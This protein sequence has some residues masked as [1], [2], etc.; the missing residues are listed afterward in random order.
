MKIEEQRAIVA[1]KIMG[2]E[3]TKT[4]FPVGSGLYKTTPIYAKGDGKYEVVADYAP[5]LELPWN[6]EQARDL[7]AKLRELVM[8]YDISWI[9]SRQFYRSRICGEHKVY[10]SESKL[11]GGAALLENASKLAIAEATA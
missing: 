2:W 9:R 5:D 1:T 3:K 4:S 6:L 10:E 7:K 11:S 8:W